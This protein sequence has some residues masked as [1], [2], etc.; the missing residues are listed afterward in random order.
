MKRLNLLLEP[1]RTE[2]IGINQIDLFKH[3]TLAKHSELNNTF[4]LTTD[5]HSYYFAPVTN[6]AII[7]I[8]FH[9]TIVETINAAIKQG[10]TLNVY[11]L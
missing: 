9:T 4:L 7:T 11:E 8:G 1:I 5:G 10:F 3:L 2:N 6:T